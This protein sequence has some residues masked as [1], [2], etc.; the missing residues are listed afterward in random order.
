[1]ILAHAHFTIS[2]F[3]KLERWKNG[4]Q[5]RWNYLETKNEIQP[6]TPLCNLVM[7]CNLLLYDTFVT[8]IGITSRMNCKCQVICVEARVQWI[9]FRFDFVFM[10]LYLIQHLNVCYQLSNLILCDHIRVQYYTWIH[11]SNCRPLIFTYLRNF[12]ITCKYWC[13]AIM[14]EGVG[15][16]TLLKPAWCFISNSRTVFFIRLKTKYLYENNIIII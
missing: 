4:R 7:V 13:T 8:P 14:D 15:C 3:W 9:V 16:H 1:M 10:W 11:V 5:V 2:V 6:P 12:W